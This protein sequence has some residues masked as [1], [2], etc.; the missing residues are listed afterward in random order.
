MH[1]LGGAA[2][3]GHTLAPDSDDALDDYITEL[4]LEEARM[5][6]PAYQRQYSSF[7]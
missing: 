6:D 5:K 4:I 1:S 7:V 3:G 2:A